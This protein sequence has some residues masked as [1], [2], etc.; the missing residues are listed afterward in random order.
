MLNKQKKPPRHAYGWAV[1]LV[2]V[3][4]LSF[5]VYCRKRIVFLGKR[6]CCADEFIFLVFGNSGVPERFLVGNSKFPTE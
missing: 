3:A 6:I 4:A 2:R 1:Q 5:A